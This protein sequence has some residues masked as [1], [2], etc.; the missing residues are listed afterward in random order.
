VGIN[1]TIP[2]I[3]YILEEFS[4]NALLNAHVNKTYKKKLDKININTLLNF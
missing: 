2:S 1:N 4:K 3:G